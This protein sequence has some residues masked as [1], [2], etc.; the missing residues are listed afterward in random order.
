MNNDELLLR[1]QRLLAR[2]SQ[3]R[4]TLADQAQVFKSPLAL[5]D[6]LRNGLQWVYRN[7]HWPL[8]AML[9]LAVMRPRRA[10]MWG[11]RMWWGWKM[12]QRARK[13]SATRP[14]R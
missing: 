8:G 3:L 14:S 2:S 1:Q 9:V 10:L 5:V 12:F 7:P 4:L 11:G 13:W 6:Q